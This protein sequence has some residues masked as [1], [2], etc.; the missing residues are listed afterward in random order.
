VRAGYGRALE[1]EIAAQRELLNR[2]ADSRVDLVIAGHTHGGQVM[3]PGLGPPM[4]L[5]CVPRAVGAAGLH[6]LDT[7]TIY[8]RRGPGCERG[9]TPRMRFFCPREITLLTIE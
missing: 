2:L 6:R 3:I 1:T 5:S 7:G 4:T 9:D 8:V